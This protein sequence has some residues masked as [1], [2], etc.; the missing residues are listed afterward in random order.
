MM[1]R[2]VP[3]RSQPR[4]HS[5]EMYPRK[6]L[7]QSRWKLEAFPTASNQI[8]NDSLAKHEKRVKQ[9]A[10]RFE[11]FT[12]LTLL[13]SVLCTAGCGGFMARRMAQAPNTY[14]SWLAPGARVAVVFS[15]KFLTNFSARF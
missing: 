6:P 1:P 15:D 9:E 7:L 2:L 8:G 5:V 12:W 14:P 3:I 11:L 13:L 10:M 4:H